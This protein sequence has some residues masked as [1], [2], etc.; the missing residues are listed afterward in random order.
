MKSLLRPTKVELPLF[1]APDLEEA[2]TDLGLR[3]LSE[4]PPLN[5]VPVIVGPVGLVDNDLS[6]LCGPLVRFPFSRSRTTLRLRGT[7]LCFIQ[8]R[9]SAVEDK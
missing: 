8:H 6:F 2:R 4:V 9:I 7:H 1:R 5:V 3:Q